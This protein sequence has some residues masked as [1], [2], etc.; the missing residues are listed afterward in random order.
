VGLIDEEINSM[1]KLLFFMM[2]L[3]SLLMMV[4]KVGSYHHDVYNG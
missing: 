2:L 4:L 3:L 1:T